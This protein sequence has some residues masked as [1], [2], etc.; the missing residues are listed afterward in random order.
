MIHTGRTGGAGI[1]REATS[2][3][4]VK[5]WSRDGSR[6]FEISFMHALALERELF[7]KVHG[8]AGA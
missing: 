4:D 2:G 1:G 3:G 5:V 6:H 7:P 8:K